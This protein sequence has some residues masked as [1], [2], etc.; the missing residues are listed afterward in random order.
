MATVCPECFLWPTPEFVATHTSTVDGS[1]APQDD[2]A[3]EQLID[4]SGLV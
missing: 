4:E 1:V 3:L 2:A